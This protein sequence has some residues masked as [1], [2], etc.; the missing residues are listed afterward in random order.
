MPAYILTNLSANL[1][2]I[3]GVSDIRKTRCS[4][5]GIVPSWV[6]VFRLQPELTFKCHMMH[7]T[8]LESE[9]ETWR[10]KDHSRKGREGSRPALELWNRT[11]LGWVHI[12]NIINGMLYTEYIFIENIIW[13]NIRNIWNRIHLQGILFRTRWTRSSTGVS[14]IVIQM[15]FVYI[16]WSEM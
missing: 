3:A 8:H 4:I 9:S 16:F 13:Y 15:I 1:V 2:T 7:R 11:H 14:I 12:Q 10:D 5:V 6:E